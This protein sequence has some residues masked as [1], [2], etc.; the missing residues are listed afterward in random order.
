MSFAFFNFKNIQATRVTFFFKMFKI[1]NIFKNRVK[2]SEKAFTFSDTSIRNSCHKFPK[3]KREFLSVAINVLPNIPKISNINMRDTS[4]LSFPQSDKENMIKVLCC[5][6]QQCLE[7]F[8][9]MTVE[10]CFETGLFRTG[11]TTSFTVFNFRNT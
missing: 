5:R 10:G 6:F 9:I 3:L 1:W 8:S 2:N 7:Y 4:K 11:L